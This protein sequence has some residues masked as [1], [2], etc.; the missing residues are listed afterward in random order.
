MIKRFAKVYD[1]CRRPNVYCVACEI[2]SAASPPLPLKKE[3]SGMMALMPIAS[4]KDET[5]VK[6]V[7]MN[8]AP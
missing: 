8:M 6:H 3:K 7:M 1:T 4:V 2:G 5:N